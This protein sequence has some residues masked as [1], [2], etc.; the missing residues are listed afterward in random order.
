M[1]IFNIYFGEIKEIFGTLD[2]ETILQ[3]ELNYEN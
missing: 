2:M 1:F 3:N